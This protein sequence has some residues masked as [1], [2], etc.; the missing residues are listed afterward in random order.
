[1]HY[2]GMVFIC[3]TQQIKTAQAGIHADNRRIFIFV[4]LWKLGW[5]VLTRFYCAPNINVSLMGNVSL[6]RFLF[7]SE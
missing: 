5:Y 3:W 7:I 1:M 6:E 2:S 4:R